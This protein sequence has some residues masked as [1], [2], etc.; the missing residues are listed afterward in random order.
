MFRDRYEREVLSSLADN[1]ARKSQYVFNALERLL[2]VVADGPLRGL[3]AERI[4]YMQA[5]LREQGRAESTIAGYLAHLRSALQRAV[6]Q[7]L[8]PT[9]P[10]IRKP[11]RAKRARTN[12]PMK[13]RPISGEEFD[14]MLDKTGE[15][16]GKELA[17][18][19][20]HY[21]TGLWWSGLRLAESF[22]LYWDRQ[23]RLFV[24]LDGKHPSGRRVTK[25]DSCRLPPSSANSCWPPP[26]MNGEV[27]YSSCGRGGCRTATR[28]PIWCLAR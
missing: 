13:G 24:E 3:T 16:V 11:K 2:P 15:S 17:D 8:L 20:R 18:L 22:E 4:S 12:T 5:K 25:T 26:T 28:A 9:L 27:E 6:D 1:T 21:M 7:G 19:W 23:D 14:R 10:K